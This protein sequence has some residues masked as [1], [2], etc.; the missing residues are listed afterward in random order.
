MGMSNGSE[1]PDRPTTRVIALL[2]QK[3]GVGKTTTAVALAGLLADQ[4]QKVL[5]VD[6]DPHG[7]MTSY[8]GQDPD[9]LTSSVFNLFQ[10]NGQVPEGLAAALLKETS[11][12]NIGLLPSSTSLAT[13]ERQSAAQGGYGLVISRALAQLWNDYQFVIID[14]P[15]LLGVSMIN[16]LAACEQLIIPVQTEFLALKGLERMVHTL[17]MVNRS[18]KQ[19]LPYTIVPT[20]FD[21]RTQASLNT[22]RLLRRDYAE[23]LWQAYIPI[24]TKLRDASLAGVVPSQLDQNARGVL[25][26]RAL[27]R[28]LLAQSLNRREQV[29]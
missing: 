12:P 7:S 1:P 2:N 26:Y 17:N 19:A 27:L 16:A 5:V 4:G 6:L 24:D 20:L 23:H 22:L 8:F 14:S 15:P 29:A 9:Q 13:L 28:F 25:A 11:H 21:R 10:H 3:G 18:R